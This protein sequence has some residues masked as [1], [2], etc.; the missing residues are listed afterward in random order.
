[1][2]VSG[3]LHLCT[4]LAAGCGEEPKRTPRPSHLPRNRLDALVDGILAITMTLLG[5]R[6]RRQ[7]G[8]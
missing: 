1:M 4:N 6:L 5:N 8:H 2:P 7:T 3:R